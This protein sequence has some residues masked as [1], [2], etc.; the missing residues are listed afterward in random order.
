MNEVTTELQR[1]TSLT[2]AMESFLRQHP[3]VW[4]PAEDLEAVG[5]RQAW[6]TRLS[7]CRRMRHMRI[8]N[9]QDRTMADGV[10]YDDNHK[11]ILR[12]K[13]YYRFVPWEPIGRDASELTQPTLFTTPDRPF[14]R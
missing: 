5:G 11:I 10:F 14:A 12:V 8:E 2:D 4:I 13:S 9:K 7:E 1:R 3:L 6:R